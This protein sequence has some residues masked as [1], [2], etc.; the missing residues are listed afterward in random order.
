MEVKQWKRRKFIPTWGG[1]DKESEPCEVNFKPPS[2]GWMAKWRELAMRSP[3]LS[4][5]SLADPDHAET[6]TR[7]TG[8][9]SEFRN[10]LI[11]DLIISI[12]NLTREG[13]PIPLIEAVGFV[14]DN[15][16]LREEVFL[17]VIESGTLKSSGGKR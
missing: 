2:V 13:E 4:A 6:V 10:A 1:N 14:L 3:D 8:E 5:D 16:G 17:A 11:S 12:D 9:V 7:W 15:E